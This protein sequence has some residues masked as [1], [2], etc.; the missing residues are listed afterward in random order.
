MRN[1][2][3][4]ALTALLFAGCATSPADTVVLTTDD[5]TGESFTSLRDPLRLAT[6]RPGLSV[7]GKDYLLVSP[8]VL[9]GTSNTGQYLWF[10][11]G[12]TV[13]RSLNGAPTPDFDRIVLEVDGSLMTFE[14]TDWQD[15]ASNEPFDVPV[16]ITRTFA[17]PVTNSQLDKIAGASE[18][19]AY[20]T[21]S[22]HRSPRYA[23]VHGEPRDWMELYSAPSI[24]GEASL[25]SQTSPKRP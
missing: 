22:E 5:S 16:R 7:V 25:A 18:L 1:S 23:L 6:D 24:F 3:F 11:I 4:I 2:L 12:T 20:V 17:T 21:N 19:H 14:L 13:D 15:T 9:T 8:V 10:G